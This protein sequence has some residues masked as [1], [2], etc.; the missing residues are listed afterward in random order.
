MTEQDWKPIETHPP[1]FSQGFPAKP[2]VLAVDA[3]GRMSV[4]FARRYSTGEIMWTFAKP[5]GE[6]THWQDLPEPP[7]PPQG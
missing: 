4:G 3:K 5:I 1:P 7:A 6:P 2:Y